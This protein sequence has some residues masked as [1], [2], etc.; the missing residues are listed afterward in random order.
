MNPLYMTYDPPFWIFEWEVILE[1]ANS[2]DWV[3]LY[4]SLL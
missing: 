1:M 2:K 3:R 4:Q